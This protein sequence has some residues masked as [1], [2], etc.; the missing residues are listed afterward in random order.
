MPALAV[1]DKSPVLPR[2]RQVGAAGQ[3]LQLIEFETEAVGGDLCQYS[4]GTLP[5]FLSATLGAGT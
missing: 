5:P 2:V 4:P 3:E 1:C